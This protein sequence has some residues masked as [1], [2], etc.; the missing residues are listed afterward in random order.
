M[1]I[2]VIVNKQWEAAPIR[3]VFEC[4]YAAKT[5]A[6]A[7]P[8]QWNDRPYPS[9]VPWS[10]TTGEFSFPFRYT[11]SVESVRVECWCL[12]D[13]KNTSDSGKKSAFI[14]KIISAGSPPDLIIGVGTAASITNR[15]QGSVFLGCRSFMHDPGINAPPSEP[16]WPGSM[17]D[18]L[19]TSGLSVPFGRM[20][21]TLSIAWTLE[22]ERRLLVAPNGGST[23]T[24]SMRPDLI[25]VSDV[26][27]GD[28][29]NMR[30]VTR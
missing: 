9:V 19:I 6:S 14:P 3:G 29:S 7:R 11:L 12:A 2:V 13:F 4:P 16:E 24:V 10:D 1:R 21:Q 28:P 8:D 22:T 18:K 17:L 25:A 20:L 30:F 23:P 15:Q 26:N 27:V 5:L